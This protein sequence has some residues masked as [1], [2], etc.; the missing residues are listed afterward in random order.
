MQTLFTV[1][2][3]YTL[4]IYRPEL[5]VDPY[6]HS[7]RTERRAF[8]SQRTKALTDLLVLNIQRWPVVPAR[9]RQAR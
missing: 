7:R 3:L 9:L 4:V 2:S 8:A 6:R 5:A 1:Q